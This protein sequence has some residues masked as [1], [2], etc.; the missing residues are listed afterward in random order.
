MGTSFLDEDAQS[1]PGQSELDAGYF[2][3][4]VNYVNTDYR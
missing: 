4:M 2:S 1:Y 3:F